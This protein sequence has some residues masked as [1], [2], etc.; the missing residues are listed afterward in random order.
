[1]YVFPLQLL[2]KEKSREAEIEMRM[3]SELVYSQLTGQYKLKEESL[4]PLFIEIW[5]LRQDFKKVE[6][7]HILREKNREADA[8]VNQALDSI[9]L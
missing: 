5:N 9:I 7:T 1:F 3:D 6:F 2:G 4:F 8:L